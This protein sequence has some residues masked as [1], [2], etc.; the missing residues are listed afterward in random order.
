MLCRGKEVGIGVAC[1]N[2]EL[3]PTQVAPILARE[4]ELRKSDGRWGPFPADAPSIG[5]DCSDRPSF[6]GDTTD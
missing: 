4:G 5:R 6:D 1:I 3:S 2:L